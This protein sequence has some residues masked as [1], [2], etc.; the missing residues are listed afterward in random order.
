MKYTGL[1]EHIR[2]CIEFSWSLWHFICGC[3]N[4]CYCVCVCFSGI[5][6]IYRWYLGHLWKYFGPTIHQGALAMRE[7]KGWA[8]PLETESPAEPM[9]TPWTALSVSKWKY[10][11]LNTLRDQVSFKSESGP[12][13]FSTASKPPPQKQMN[14]PT[15]EPLPKTQKTPKN[16]P[17]VV[18]VLSGHPP[19]K[20]MQRNKF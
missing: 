15:K 6:V 8:C 4:L 5:I 9:V 12:C 7:G 1:Q 11:Q 16:L 3:K 18:S 14:K 17:C 2:L 19:Q 20:K 10:L 13:S